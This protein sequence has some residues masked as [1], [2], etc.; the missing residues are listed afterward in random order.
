[1]QVFQGNGAFRALG[2]RDFFLFWSSYFVSNVGSWMQGVAQG[3]LLFDLTSSPFYLGLFSSL[4]MVLL[5]CFFV[6]GGLMSDR[7]DR[8]KVMLW[9][10]IISALTALGMAVLVSLKMIQVWH[11][12]VFGAITSTAWAFEQPV[13]QAL[14]PQ[15]VSRE[16]LVNALAL[17]AVT[18]NGA[19]L[20]GPALVG[21]SVGRI[22]IDGCFYV[23]VVSYLAIIVALFFMRIPR[24]DTTIAHS[25]VLRSLKD[26]LSYVRTERVIVT[27]L[28]VSACF[29]IF[30]RSYVI[31]LPVFVKEVLRLGASGL[32]FLAAAPGLGTI[33]GS[34]SLAAFGRIEARPGRMLMMLFGFSVV[35]FTFAASRNFDLSFACLVVVGAL[36]TVFETLLQTSIQLRV[37]E[38]FRG[39]VLGFYGLTSGGLREFGGMQAGFLAEWT[40][41]PFAI[42]TGVVVLIIVGAFFL[43][44]G[45]RRLAR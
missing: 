31:L 26:G 45:L 43:G 24:R 42:E 7:V 1:M 18:W 10:Q 6:L 17:N 36:S 16:D 4:R 37:A 15:L 40:S 20:I 14:I 39:R 35:L 9:I 38:A 44:A 13:R 29:N 27:F 41:A 5:L 30:G 33:I 3:W 19:G 32:G 2:Y 22:G 11:I 34:L 21:L 23:N 12:F 8:R 28:I 25:S